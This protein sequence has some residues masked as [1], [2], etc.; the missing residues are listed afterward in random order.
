LLGK[1]LALPYRLVI[2]SLR[3]GRVYHGGSGEGDPPCVYS[4]R[5]G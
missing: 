3:C 4:F 5:A 1:P 2:H